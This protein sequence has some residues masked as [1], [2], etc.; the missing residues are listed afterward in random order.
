MLKTKIISKLLMPFVAAAVCTTC[1]FTSMIQASAEENMATSENGVEH[2]TVLS[3]ED[4]T[5]LLTNLEIALNGGDGEVWTTVKNKFTLFPSTV[6]V[7]VQLYVSDVYCEDYKD[8]TL[9]ASN[10]TMDL[11]LGKTIEA[12]A[13]TGGKQCYWMGRMR[14]KI[15]GD[16]WDERTVGVGLYSATGEFLGIS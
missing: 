10:S 5:R 7:I 14:Y 16:P 4:S 15:D 9:V 8:M 12:R 1:T 13:S 11:D 2:E 3:K 6:Y